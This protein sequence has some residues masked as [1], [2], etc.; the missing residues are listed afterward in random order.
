MIGIQSSFTKWQIS[1]DVFGSCYHKW[2]L[3]KWKRRYQIGLE[4]FFIAHLKA[5][6]QEQLSHSLEGLQLNKITEKDALALEKPFTK[7]EVKQAVLIM[8]GDKAPGPDGFPIL[9]FHKFWGLFKE[10]IMVLINEFF[11]KWR[12]LL[13]KCYFLDFDP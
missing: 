13:Y 3:A 4:S 2:F 1:E 12:R 9:V 11:Y 8:A 7:D 6:P 10:G 5:K